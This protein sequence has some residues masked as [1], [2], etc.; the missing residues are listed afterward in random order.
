VIGSFALRPFMEHGR[1]A[2]MLAFDVA[3]AGF[4]L[5]LLPVFLDGS[6]DSIRRHAAENDANRV[7]LLAIGAAIA[8]AL[9]ATIASELTKPREF[10]AVLVI[11]TLG[12]AWLFGNLLYTLH[13]AHL[14]YGEGHGGTGLIF[15]DTKTPDYGDFLYF[16]LT[17][18][19]TFQTAD[20]T[21]NSR[22]MRRVALAQSLV[23]FVFNIGILAFTINTL[24]G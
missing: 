6:A 15:P 24:G 4:I 22:A 17:L 10:I 20:I 12:I 2:M 7:M 23:A 3:A 1:D 18:G 8:M 19:M 14:Y 16:A 21:I 11:A 13:Y 5:S 9:L